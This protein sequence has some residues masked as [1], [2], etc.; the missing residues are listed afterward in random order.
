MSPTRKAIFKKNRL[1]VSI[2]LLLIVLG[3]VFGYFYERQTDSVPVFSSGTLQ[4]GE[5]TVQ[6]SFLDVGQGDSILIQTPHDRFVLVD[7]G[8]ESSE[9]RLLA[10]LAQAGA[11]SLDYVLFTHPHEDH[12]GGGDAVIRALLCKNVLM[13]KAYTNTATYDALLTAL[14]EENCTVQ[15]AKAGFAFDLDGVSVELLAPLQESEEDLNNVSIVAKVTYGE[16]S[17]LLTGDAEKQV[18]Q[19]LLDT[20]SPKQ[21]HATVLKAGHHGSSTS[22]SDAFVRAVRPSFY[23]ISCGQDNDYGHPHRETLDRLQKE[24]IP[25]CRTDQNG[26]VTVV[27]DGENISVLCEKGEI[28]GSQD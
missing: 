8:P 21:L 7:A 2:A 1:S 18:E 16:I 25:W 10:Q 23:V 3:A 27:T 9:Q 22:S 11:S 13:P 14:E 19:Q 12:I 26:T 24:S 4:D 15:A 20:Y 28:Y 5:P 17:F 6:V